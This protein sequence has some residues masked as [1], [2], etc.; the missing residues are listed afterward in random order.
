MEEGFNNKL[1]FGEDRIVEG[2][3]KGFWIVFCY[4]VFQFR[5]RIGEFEGFDNLLG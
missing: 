1:L 3:G 4:V 5:V 2:R